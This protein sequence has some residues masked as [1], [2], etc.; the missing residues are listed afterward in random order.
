MKEEAQFKPLRS[1]GLDSFLENTIEQVK[2]GQ[3]DPRIAQSV[4]YLSGIL[5][6]V[7]EQR[8]LEERLSDMERIVKAQHQP[9]TSL[10]DTAIAVQEPEIQFIQKAMETNDPQ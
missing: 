1:D 2:N 6:K 5:L 7:I 9:S 8:E 3:L 10:M 4:G